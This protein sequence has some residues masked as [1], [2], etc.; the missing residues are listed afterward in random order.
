M[1][2]IILGYLLRC[3]NLLY[4]K[5][6]HTYEQKCN[7]S[8]LL[9]S[10]TRIRMHSKRSKFINVLL[11]S[12]LLIYVNGWR[13]LW[14]TNLLGVTYRF[15]RKRNEQ[16]VR[17]YE[18]RPESKVTKAGQNVEIFFSKLAPLFCRVFPKGQ[19]KSSNVSVPYTM[20]SLQLNAPTYV[21]TSSVRSIYRRCEIR[22]VIRFFHLRNESATNVHC[23]F[24]ETYGS[25]V[26]TRQ[27]FIKLFREN[28]T[29]THHEERMGGAVCHFR[30]TCVGQIKEKVCNDR[31]VTLDILKKNYHTC[32]EVS[33]VKSYHKNF[34][35]RSCVQGRSQK[36]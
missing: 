3:I 5:S 27:N 14:F 32:H 19:I 25:E 23:Q 15:C 21:S 9:L 22:S 24:V 35:I 17:L 20:S 16:I 1:F 31:R 7:S 2:Q 34:V 29:D 36:C 26:M 12:N 10:D 6:N 13:T 30:R 11:T 8:N 28:R 4:A 18:R 33:Q